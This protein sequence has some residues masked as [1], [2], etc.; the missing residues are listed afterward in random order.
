MNT[1]KPAPQPTPPPSPQL[2]RLM[3]LLHGIFPRHVWLAWG[4][5]M[6]SL[7][8]TALTALY[9]KTS[10]ENLAQHEFDFICNEIQLNIENR[11]AAS[12]Q[13]LYSGA[14]LFDASG[15]VTRT[16]WKDYT[17]HL[18]I[19]KQLPGIQGVGFALLIPSEQLA[20]HTQSLRSEGFPDYSVNPAGERS[21]YS[22]I[23]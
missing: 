21:I 8:I 16:Q 11:L 5:L 7:I 4:M 3:A 18:Q 13:L 2:S 20:Q 15:A 10:A 22:S 6:A 12:A 9:V 23:I 1:K 17:G 19:E 14:G